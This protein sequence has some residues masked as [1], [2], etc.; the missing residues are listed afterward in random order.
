M[1]INFFFSK[2]RSHANRF[3]IDR[4]IVFDPTDISPKCVTVLCLTG[5]SF[6]PSSAAN[7]SISRHKIWVV[8]LANLVRI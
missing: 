1:I 5:W 3:G 7:F 6:L 8:A 4:I 2:G